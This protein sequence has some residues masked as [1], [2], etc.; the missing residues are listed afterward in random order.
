MNVICTDN[1]FRA[2]VHVC[3]DVFNVCIC[4]G[5][6]ELLIGTGDDGGCRRGGSGD[7]VYFV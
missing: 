1:P 4:A 6:R 5:V 7:G 3:L 2:Y